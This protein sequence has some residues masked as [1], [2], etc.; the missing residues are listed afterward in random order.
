MTSAW[1]CRLKRTIP[2]SSV[3]GLRHKDYYGIDAHNCIQTKSR[4]TSS[5]LLLLGGLINNLRHQTLANNTH[6]STINPKRRR[7]RSETL[8]ELL[9]LLGISKQGE[10]KG[11]QLRIVILV[12]GYAESN[13]LDFLVGDATEGFACVSGCVRFMRAA[14]LWCQPLYE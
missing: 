5:S 12:P 11:I 4:L 10:S 7:T 13:A 2:T 14:A 6:T 8:L 3:V 9:Y 1:I